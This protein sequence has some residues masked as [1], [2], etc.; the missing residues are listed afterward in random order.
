MAGY[1]P[2]DVL[3]HNVL[4]FKIPVDDLV[5]MQILDTSSWSRSQS[6]NERV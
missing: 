2:V 1:L 3:Q 5:F 4:R 6:E